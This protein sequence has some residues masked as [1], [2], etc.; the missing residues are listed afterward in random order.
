[1]NSSIT[2]SGKIISELSEKIPS[3]IIALNELIKN[4]YDAGSNKVLIILN[5][6]EKKLKICDDGCGMDKND[7]DTLF[8]ISDSKKQYG[9]KN[10]YNRY[11]QGSKGLGFLSVF[12]FGEYVVWKTNKDCGL[13][14][15]IDYSK[16]IGTSDITNYQIEVTNDDSIS[17]GTEIEIDISDYNLKSL[18]RYLSEDKNYEKIINAFLDKDFIIELDVDEKKYSN[19]KKVSI[20]KYLP[21]KQLYYIKYK[22]SDGKVQYYYNNILILSFDYELKSDKY[23]VEIELQIFKLSRGDKAE[24]SKLFYNPQ[25]DLTPLLYINSNLFNNYS[26][27]DPGINKNIKSSLSLNQMIG[28]IKIVSSDSMINFNSDRTQFLQNELTDDIITFLGNINKEIQKYGSKYRKHLVDLDFLLVKRVCRK[29]INLDKDYLRRIISDKFLFKDKVK[30][31]EEKNR[32]IYSI[33]GREISINIYEE[34]KKQKEDNNDDLNKGDQSDNGEENDGASELKDIIPAVIELKN[35]YIKV[36]VPSKQIDLTQYIKNSYNSYGEDI[37]NS[38]I[39]IKVD[40]SEKKNGILESIK[41]PCVKSI[42]YSYLDSNTGLVNVEMLIEF[43]Q[44]KSKVITNKND[45]GALIYL[46]T[47]K[48]Y[49]VNFNIILESLINEINKLNSVG[50]FDEVIVCSLR[51]L[52]EI[53]IDSIKK[54]RK[55]G[56]IFNGINKLEERVGKVVE[57]INNKKMYISEISKATEIDFNSLKNI[58]NPGDFKRAVEEANLG[59]HKSDMYLSKN[60]D[61]EYIAKKAAVFIVIVNEMINNTQII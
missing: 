45:K 61:K 42:E 31:R 46:P 43:F 38:K 14:F 29:D 28:Y 33:F 36:E 13:K 18:K 1:M 50:K 49:K 7:I 3:N 19:E 59:A 40:N 57:Y 23:Q 41:V 35:K 37:A 53:S 5:S 60:F 11:T 16:L 48:E 26:I 15:A 27:F 6:E 54:D 30:I 21:K 56:D 24:I 25:D 17:K 39:I 47:Q 58:L 52:F 51:A 12:K 55:F 20:K 8:H 2:V 9:L 22:S 4:S 32:V 44:P 10:K 34:S